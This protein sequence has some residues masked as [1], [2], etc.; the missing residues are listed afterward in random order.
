VAFNTERLKNFGKFVIY[1][2]LS[3]SKWTNGNRTYFGHIKWWL[4]MRRFHFMYI[5]LNVTDLSP[6]SR[7]VVMKG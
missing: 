7:A 1:M 4:I 2:S 3:T 5:R 6:S